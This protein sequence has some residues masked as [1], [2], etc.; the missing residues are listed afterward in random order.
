MIILIL[1]ICQVLILALCATVLTKPAKVIKANKLAESYKSLA[2]KT[3]NNYIQ[4]KATMLDVTPEEIKNRL[5]E[6]YTLKDVD[7][8]CENL[9]QYSLNMN[10]LPFRVDREVK[11][12]VKPSTNEPLAHK[13]ENDSAVDDLTLKLAGLL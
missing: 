12:S 11:V 8:V 4:A 10:Q 9:Q 6:S 1:I 5:P 3:V 7:R 2:T 13:S